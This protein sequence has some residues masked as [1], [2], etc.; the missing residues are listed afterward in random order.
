[1]LA[2]KKGVTQSNRN[3]TD[4]SQEGL[5]PLSTA[6][7]TEVLSVPVCQWPALMPSEFPIAFSPDKALSQIPAMVLL[8]ACWTQEQAEAVADAIAA[9]HGFQLDCRERNK[10]RYS[11]AHGYILLE[12]ET[13]KTN[14]H[15]STSCFALTAELSLADGSY[16]AGLPTREYRKIPI[17]FARDI[18]FMLWNLLDFL[19]DHRYQG[20]IKHWN[21]AKAYGFIRR[22]GAQDVFLHIRAVPY[23]ERH[24]L[25]E[26]VRVR[27]RLKQTPRGLEAEDVIFPDCASPAEAVQPLSP[28]PGQDA[29]PAR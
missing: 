29:G 14:Y 24:R 17:R 28:F 23:S 25:A 2:C 3:S 5:I 1:M 16:S 8:T 4:Q 12:M 11:K 10:F 22:P 9:R 20:E 19:P 6:A 7:E 15:E 27:F 13:W 26:Q 21:S 18:N